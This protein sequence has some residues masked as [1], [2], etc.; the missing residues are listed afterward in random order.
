MGCRESSPDQGQLA[1]ISLWH[2]A[3]K[4]ENVDDIVA[5][6]RLVSSTR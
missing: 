5:R 4:R 3:C 6:P 1:S 2:Q